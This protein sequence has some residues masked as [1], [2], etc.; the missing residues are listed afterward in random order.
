LISPTPVIGPDRP[1][2]IDNYA[3]KSFYHEGEMLRKFIQQQPNMHVI[4]GD[5]HWQYASRDPETGIL[6]FSCGPAS[7]EH[8]GGWK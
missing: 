2:K 5:R 8:A 1:Q 6:E 7:N 3:N 4:T